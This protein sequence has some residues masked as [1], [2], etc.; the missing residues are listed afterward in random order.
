VGRGDG[1][2]ETARAAWEQ[3]RA[4]DNDHQRWSDSALVVAVLVWCLVA[5]RHFGPHRAENDLLQVLIVIPLVWRRRWPTGVFA[6]LA[7][8]ALLQWLVTVPLPADIAL[9]V[10]LFTLAVYERPRRALQGAAILSVGVVLASIRWLPAGDTTKSVVLLFGMVVAALFV[11]MT[12]KTSRAYLESLEERARRLEFER[13]QQVRLSAAAERSRIARE[14]HDVVAHNVSIMVTLAEGARAASRSDATKAAE[15]MGEVS[16]VG[17]SALTDMRHLLGVLKLEDK[18][19][20]APQPK[21]SE[22]PRL[23]D[24]VRSTGLAVDFTESGRPFDITP[25][26]ELTLYRIVQESLTNILKHADHP[27]SAKIG[28]VFDEPFIHITVRDDGRR[29][30]SNSKGHGLKGMYERASS[31]GGVLAAGPRPSG[32]WEVSSRIP[33]AVGGKVE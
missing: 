28:V 33:V 14:M 31:C 1:H 5:T 10:A 25:G 32:G 26:G 16:A 11:G 30:E 22:L 27:S 19:E 17:R 6:L 21:L 29:C 3:C 4:W 12:L 23:L 20:E 15:V 13:D 18:R 9:L 7:A 8:L 24:R 2:F